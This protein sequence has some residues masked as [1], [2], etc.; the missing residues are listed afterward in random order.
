MH[1]FGGRSLVPSLP[2]FFRHRLRL[3]P[4]KAGKPGNEAKGVAYLMDACSYADTMASHA[5]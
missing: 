3:M 5:L 1:R 2:S 4:K